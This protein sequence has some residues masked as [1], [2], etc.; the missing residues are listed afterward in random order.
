MGRV[1]KGTAFG[2]EQLTQLDTLAEP[3]TSIWQE[4]IKNIRTI[5]PDAGDDFMTLPNT[6]KMQIRTQLNA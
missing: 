4:N 1:A 5:V 6:E 3:I 2:A